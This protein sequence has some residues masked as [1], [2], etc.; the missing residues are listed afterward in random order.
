VIL[1]C[2]VMSCGCT[3]KAG[4]L[5]LDPLVYNWLSNVYDLFIASNRC[6]DYMLLTLYTFGRKKQKQYFNINVIHVRFGKQ[7]VYA[8]D[9]CVYLWWSFLLEQER[10]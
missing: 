1:S 5:L 2:I 9:T 6:F 7:S 4:L 8:R 10:R 3:A